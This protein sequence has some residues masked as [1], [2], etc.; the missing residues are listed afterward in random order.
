MYFVASRLTLSGGYAHRESADCR[1]RVKTR[2]RD[3]LATVFLGVSNRDFSR[4]W[5][6]ECVANNGEWLRLFLP[7]LG[8]HDAPSICCARKAKQ[9][10]QSLPVLLYLFF[11]IMVVAIMPP[12][13]RADVSTPDTPAG[14]T[15]RAFL[16]A[17]N[18]GE[19]NRIAAYVKEY[20]P[21][22]SADG[23]TSF[24]SQTGGFTLVSIVHSARIRSHFW[25][26]GAETTSMPTEPCNLLALHH[27]VLERSSLARSR[28]PVNPRAARSKENVD[29][30]GESM[31]QPED[32]R[33]RSPALEAHLGDTL[34]RKKVAQCP[35]DPEIFFNRRVGGIAA[36]GG[37]FEV[38]APLIRRKFGKSVHSSV[39]TRFG[40]EPVVPM[41]APQAAGA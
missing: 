33:E 18:S 3:F 4:K 1:S 40:Q 22:N 5:V 9:H 8:G 31:D 13:A 26:T 7:L 16:D 41:P 17:F 10:L 32:L 11:A 23:L 37:L 6:L 25:F 38:G 28:L 24:S 12:R 21:E 39:T 36:A 30:F 27:H 20:D 15:L 19:H 2:N 34:E 29:V 35:A 14:R